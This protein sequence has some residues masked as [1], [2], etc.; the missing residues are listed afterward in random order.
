ME[1]S[2]VMEEMN[3]IHYGWSWLHQPGLPVREVNHSFR[4]L[5][6]AV[7]QGWQIE[8]PVQVLPSADTE[9]WTYY[10]ILTHASQGWMNRLF[11]PALPEVE[12]YVEQ[13]RFQV[14]EDMFY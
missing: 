3:A 1:G 6:A 7:D 11:V 13:N 8:E 14:I 4:S 5:L 12:R 2:M 10:F 9:T